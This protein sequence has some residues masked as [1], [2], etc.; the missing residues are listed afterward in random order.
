MCHRTLSCFVIT[1]TCLALAGAPA[2]VSAQEPEPVSD[3][4]Q[5]A[6]EI[7]DRAIEH[8]GGEL[9]ERNRTRLTISSASG[10]FRVISKVHGD[11]FDHEVIHDTREGASRRVRVTNDIVEQWLDGEPVPVPEGEEQR[12]RDFVMARVYFPFLPYRLNDPSVIK[13]DLGTEVWDGETLRKVLVTF[14]SGSSTDAG[15]EYLYW[16]DPETGRVA[17]FAYSFE[18][19]NGGLRLRK[20]FNHRRF[21]GLMFF[22]SENWGVSGKGRSVLEVTPELAGKM[23]RISTVTISDVDVQ[24]LERVK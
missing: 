4:A 15:D 20:A 23:E 22:D 3:A 14:E 16:F 6:Q 17:Q 24:V 10:S 9:Y 21:T 19:G 13:K 12:L 18:A 2:V 1:L 11:T 5:A 7:V 8:H